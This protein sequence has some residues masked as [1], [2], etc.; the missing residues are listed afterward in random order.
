MSGTGECADTLR[1]ESTVRRSLLNHKRDFFQR[2]D[3]AEDLFLFTLLSLP[4]NLEEQPLY[5]PCPRALQH[6]FNGYR[7]GQQPWRSEQL[8]QAIEGERIQ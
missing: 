2:L 6:S 4:R 5:P 7:P 1:Q 3:V 8:A